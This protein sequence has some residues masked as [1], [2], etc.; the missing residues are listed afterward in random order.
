M[1]SLT[2]ENEL[3]GAST[4]STGSVSGLAPSRGRGAGSGHCDESGKRPTKTKKKTT[5]KKKTKFRVATWNVGTLKGRSN[6]VVETLSRRKIDICGVQE[7]RW[8]GSLQNGQ[9][10]TLKGEKSE[11]K[12]F[13]SA[14]KSGHGGAGFLLAK[15]WEDKVCNVQRISD[16]IILL[17]LIIGKAIFN[18]ISVYAP[19]TNLSIDTKQQFYDQLQ[20]TV[21]KIPPAEILIPVG[22][23]NGHVGTDAGV[24]HVVHGG[25][26][27][28]IRNSDGERILEFATAN[29]LR[30]GNTWFKKRNSHLITYSSGGCSTQLDYILYRK[31]FS[32]A[33]SNVKVIAGYPEKELV[34]QHH[35]VVC[36]FT[37]HTPSA[38]KRKF[39]PR[40]KT[41]KLRDPQTASLFE[42][43]FRKNMLSNITSPVSETAN[44]KPSN[45]VEAAWTNLKGPLLAAAAEVCGI[46]KKHQWK[47]E[48]WWWNGD[49][50]DAVQRKRL[51]FKKYKTLLGQGKTA[52]A[53]EAKSEYDSAKRVA[54]HV[55][56]LA[57]SE[58]E[59]EEFSKISPNGDGV[60]R[61]AKQI[62]RA[63]Q[64]VV[65]EKC[66]RNDAGVLA[67][68]DEDKMKAWVEH[69]SRLLNVE[70]EWPSN[71][72]PEVAPTAG[73][74]PGVSTAQ[75]RKAISKMRNGKAAGPSGIIAEMLKASGE[76]GINLA[77]E[78]TQTVFSSGVV[79]T[80]WEES[81]QFNSIQF[82]LFP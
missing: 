52:E 80:D 30:I 50:E 64:D 61:I 72:L 74:P 36:D 19:Q 17:K 31:S 81:F 3:G 42:E 67:L 26:G 47:R 48:T 25:H 40:L 51:S 56:W 23:W 38:K 71:E 15:S 39:T 58:A 68:T 14:N 70:F 82:S 33:V 49:V 73:P 75:I 8:K 44:D 54:K 18:F 46:T 79:P 76:S 1:A 9:T 5:S 55:V 35:L 53:K 41:W 60:F 12:F 16:R 29:G 69:Y 63:N 11:Y 21:A 6:E 45:V 2:K 37:V 10:R 77:R 65:G 20:S 13:F 7:H 34:K 24:Y 27:Y 32:R 66:V 22:D 43:A 28:G 59:K 78:M 57:K 62:D 4:S